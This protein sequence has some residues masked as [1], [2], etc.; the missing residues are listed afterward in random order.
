MDST[1]QL[2]IDKAPP[3][4]FAINSGGP[5]GLDTQSPVWGLITDWHNPRCLLAVTRFLDGSPVLIRYDK[6]DIYITEKGWL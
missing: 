5:H 6:H 2:V 3:I 4:G 1:A